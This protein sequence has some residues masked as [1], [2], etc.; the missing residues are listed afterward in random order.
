M[1]NEIGNAAGK[2]WN[3]LNAEGS[4]ST[5]KLKKAT[6]LNE[7]L[8]NQAIG[9]LARENKIYFQKKGKNYTTILRQ[10]INAF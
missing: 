6:R 5:E 7:K 4:C 9:W 8:M 2:I 10:R 1:N 3:A